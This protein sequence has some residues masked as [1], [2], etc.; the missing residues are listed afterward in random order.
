MQVSTEGLPN[1]P[2]A[3]CGGGPAGIDAIEGNLFNITEFMEEII[4]LGGRTRV[5]EGLTGYVAFI[6]DK[7]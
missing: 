4:S 2:G 1:S 6:Y 7:N 5:H 3:I